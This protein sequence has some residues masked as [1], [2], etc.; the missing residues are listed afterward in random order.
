MK[1]IISIIKLVRPLN[2]LIMVITMFLM[3]Y[4]VIKPFMQFSELSLQ[5]T[6]NDFVYM[7]LAVIFIAAAA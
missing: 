6:R 3:R 1:K 2:L 4:C 7:L 5:I